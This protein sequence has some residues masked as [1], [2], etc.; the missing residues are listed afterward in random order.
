MSHY[1]IVSPLAFLAFAFIFTFFVFGTN[2]ASAATYEIIGN[3]WSSDNSSGPIG[4]CSIPP[5][6]AGGL[7]WV[8]FSNKT[9]GTA[10]PYGVF[11]DSATGDFSGYA[12]SSNI[13]WI[14]FNAFEM[15]KCSTNR[16]QPNI[17][18]NPD[19]PDNCID[20]SPKK[21]QVNITTDTSGKIIGGTGL[22]TGWARACSIFVSGCSGAVR[23]DNQTGTWD[24]WIRLSGVTTSGTS[25]GMRLDTAL[26]KFRG[27]VCISPCTPP[28]PPLCST[29]YAWSGS[30]AADDS[31]FGWGI[32]MGGLGINIIVSGSLS[33]LLSFWADQTT[34]TSGQSIDLHWITS[35]N[36][37]SCTASGAWSGSKP[38]AITIKSQSVSPTVSSAY[39][40]ECFDSLGNTTGP[41]TV[42]ITVTAVA[43]PTAGICGSAN[44]VPSRSAP[45]TNLCSA[46]NPSAVIKDTTTT[47]N[48]WKWNCFGINGGA[49][50]SCSSDVK[51]AFRI[52]QF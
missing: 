18:G 5:C 50:V 52:I 29:C 14:T 26:L 2:L 27:P 44:G 41:R 13:G 45:V 34:I 38:V 49:S 7:G 22:V 32:N 1:R 3:G 39:T 40:L 51:K 12:W 17:I 37:V 21:A 47:P 43:V 46:G 23:P 19:S 24:G 6:V 20:A 4:G 33:P 42:N 15:Q 16:I 48:Q 8:S 35:S 28:S 10:I 9:D 31:G 30:N 36:V 11:I 25:Y